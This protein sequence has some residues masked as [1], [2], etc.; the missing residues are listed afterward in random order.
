[1]N[2]SSRNKL[3]RLPSYRFNYESMGAYNRISYA[4][5]LTP[6]GKPKAGVTILGVNSER[7]EEIM[8]RLAD[9]LEVFFHWI[10]N[11]DE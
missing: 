4:D 10:N 5:V 2:E 1:M 8:V 9:G 7:P 11:E 3:P 6:E